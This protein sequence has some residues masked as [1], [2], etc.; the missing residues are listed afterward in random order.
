M[1]A[2]EFYRVVTAFLRS[3][4]H[5]LQ[6]GEMEDD[7]SEITRNA[8]MS[9][10][11]LIFIA[12][13]W[14]E[15]DLIQTVMR[16]THLMRPL[17]EFISYFGEDWFQFNRVKERSLILL[18]IAVLFHEENAKQFMSLNLDFLS[19][20]DYHCENSLFFLLDVS[21]GGSD[22][23]QNQWITPNIRSLCLSLIRALCQ[24]DRTLQRNGIDVISILSNESISEK[25]TDKE[26]GHPL[27]YWTT[28]RISSYFLEDNKSMKLQC[29]STP[30]I[31]NQL[32][33]TLR[34]GSDERL[35]IGILLLIIT[36]CY[37]C[38]DAIYLLFSNEQRMGIIV[39]LATDQQRDDYIRGMATYILA[40]CLEF[41][42]CLSPQNGAKSAPNRKRRNKKF[43]HFL[44]HIVTK[45][46]KMEKFKSNLEKLL[47]TTEF[48]SMVGVVPKCKQKSKVSTNAM[49][50]NRILAIQEMF[51]M[52]IDSEND[53]YLALRQNRYKKHLFTSC[54]IEHIGTLPMW[55]SSVFPEWAKL[56]TKEKITK[57]EEQRASLRIQAMNQNNA[58]R[59]Q[60]KAQKQYR[61][62]L[63]STYFFKQIQIVRSSQ[64]LVPSPE[65]QLYNTLDS[66]VLFQTKDLGKYIEDV[67]YFADF[68]RICK[69]A[70]RLM[71]H[72]LGITDTRTNY[73]MGTG[74]KGRHPNWHFND[75]KVTGATL[76]NQVERLQKEAVKIH[77]RNMNRVLREDRTED[78]KMNALRS[79]QLM[80]RPG[81]FP[82]VRH[83]HLY[84]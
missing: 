65:N 43:S 15:I 34:S 19:N 8:I 42:P 31:I 84:L 60:E 28:L 18:R 33:S 17:L 63:L 64:I 75:L 10:N 44:F 5:N 71:E 73:R 52:E 59:K 16:E 81:Q 32:F 1:G 35:L 30:I 22:S 3:S 50:R 6:L 61:S 39:E 79:F 53:E 45:Q 27:Q 78:D 4:I 11:I 70:Y 40:M 49:E 23:A 55:M 46:I 58:Q 26:C 56:E 2:K 77:I 83:F 57:I 12:T 80:A 36:M 67:F 48:S 20:T 41:A 7:K 24:S 47:S 54:I 21:Y 62:N 74:Q 14:G 38:R 51:A 76:K 13:E 25:T 69:D 72:D 82:L 9:M 66:C 37:E 29:A 68:E